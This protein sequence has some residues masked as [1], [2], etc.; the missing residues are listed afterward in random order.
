M[1][2]RPA[3][4]RLRMKGKGSP[5]GNAGEPSSVGSRLN[6]VVEFRDEKADSAAGDQPRRMNSELVVCTGLHN[7]TLKKLFLFILR[8]YVT[9]R[10]TRAGE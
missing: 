2:R 3:K 4:L 8:C 5:R 7:D 1:S 9:V 10:L 6:S